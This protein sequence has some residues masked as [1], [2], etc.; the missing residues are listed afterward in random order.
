MILRGIDFGHTH[1]ATG[2]QGFIGD[3]SEY[4]QHR[5]PFF[6]PNFTGMTFV[7]KTITLHERTTDNGANMDIDPDTLRPREL[8]PKCIVINWK[9]K[10]VLN[11]V[12]LVNIGLEGM[13]ARGCWQ[14]RTSPWLL[15]F[16]STA[17]TAEKRLAEWTE[18]CYIL[19]KALPGFNTLIG[20]HINYSCP[21]AGID[22]KKLFPEVSVQLRV[23]RKI[24]GEKMVFIPKFSVT[25]IPIDVE[26]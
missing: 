4:P 7:A 12:N 5:I 23:G 24:L 20:I 10:A 15:S 3:G 9:K 19:K 11:A 8:F 14:K 17:D 26:T 2:L 16:M 18:F 22:T 25:Q 13:L 1:G 21:S 6:H